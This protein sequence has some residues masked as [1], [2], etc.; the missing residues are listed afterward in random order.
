MLCSQNAA[1]SSDRMSHQ[2][3]LCHVVHT[4]T[5]VSGTLQQGL[6]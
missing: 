6:R 4:A 2:G 5:K 1:F 3:R